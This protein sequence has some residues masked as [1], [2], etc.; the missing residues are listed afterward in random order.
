M[1]AA[2]VLTALGAWLAGHALL[3]LLPGADRRRS[4][5]ELQATAALLGLV[6]LPALLA[7]R[8]ALAG[9]V[10][11]VE[12]ILILALPA[13]AGALLLC[14][15]VRGSRAGRP[16]EPPTAERWKAGQ[17]VLALLVLGFAGFAVFYPTSMP[18]HVFDPLYHYAYKGKLVLN[19]GFGT[20]AWSDLEGPVGRVITHPDYPPG[21][22]SLQALL[23]CV[24][25]RF[26]EDATKALLSLYVLVP[27]AWLY[28]VLRPR[29]RTP[30]LAAALTWLSLPILYYTRAPHES[31][32]H[33]MFGLIAGYEAGIERFPEA[34]PW[35]LPDGW[36]LDGAADLPLAALFTGAFLHLGGLLPGRSA[37]AAGA[38]GDAVVGGVFLGGAVLM[39][40]E[41]TALAAVLL[42]A[43]ALGALARRLAGG[44][45]EPLAALVLRWGLGLLVALGL[46][47]AWLVV[48][49][50]I[51]SID[52]NY[53]E[54]LT[55]S[56]LWEARGRAGEV[57]AGFAGT[58]VAILRWELVWPL[59]AAALLGSL[60][61]PRALLRHPAFPAVL[62]VL[63]AIA[64][65][66]A[67]LL[68][69]PWD[70]ETLFST[71]IPGRLVLHVT[72]LAV[73]ATMALLWKLPE[74]VA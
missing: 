60:A 22:P 57:A 27:A 37:D 15:N 34:L 28:G 47:A 13:L 48:R 12:G 26:D 66:F 54:R 72:P 69:T 39:K 70:L 52:E 25:G 74:E 3:G 63:G 18:V 56:G 29:G 9:P 50:E 36:I 46:A 21:L 45:G 41:G 31:L 73:L 10:G 35:S 71:V 59:F 53:P 65:Y 58:F 51:P 6:L 43:L 4:P 40:N 30:A 67:I 44:P 14:R 17:A 11:R 64:L 19:E 1:T 7:T 62:A 61:R 16:Q 8:V 42:L 20:P 33:A 32:P 49:G 5:L 55:L 24:A 23:A 68:V 38:R 2:T